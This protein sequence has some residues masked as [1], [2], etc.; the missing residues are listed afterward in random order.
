[1]IAVNAGMRHLSGPAR[2]R[3]GIVRGVKSGPIDVCVFVECGCAAEHRTV[4][5]CCL[6]LYGLLL[7]LLE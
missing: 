5:I 1:M 4:L 3:R 2:G 6:M 7:D